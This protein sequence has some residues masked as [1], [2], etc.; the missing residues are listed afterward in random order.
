M[1]EIAAHNALHPTHGRNCSCHDKWSHRLKHLVAKH[2][3]CDKDIQSFALLCHYFNQNSPSLAWKSTVPA[4]P[5][6]EDS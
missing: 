1:A 5:G 3:T 6:E 2:A 4:A